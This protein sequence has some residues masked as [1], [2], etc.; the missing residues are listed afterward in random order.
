MKRLSELYAEQTSDCDHVIWHRDEY[1]KISGSTSYADIE[2]RKPIDDAV[3]RVIEA[4]SAKFYCNC[5]ENDCAHTKLREALTE[6]R[7]VLEGKT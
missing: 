5:V 7:R 4:A 2:K 3:A 6:L 1:G